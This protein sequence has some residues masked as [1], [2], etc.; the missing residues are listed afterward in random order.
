MDTSSSSDSH[1]SFLKRLL[2]L[3]GLFRAPDSAEDI[4]QEIQEILEEGEEQ[5]LISKDEGRLITSILEFKDTLAHE[6]MTPRSDMVCAAAS[7]DVSEIISLIVDK[8]YT[9]IPIYAD[10]P[11]NIVG[12]LH[13]KDLL[14]YCLKTDNLP[15]ASELVKP[16]FFVMETRKI[17]DLLKDF[18]NQ[19]IHMG[20][21]TDEFGSVRGLVTLEDVVEEIVG[22][23]RDEYDKTE[24]KWKV[25]H[26]DTVLVD[27]RVDIEEVEEFFGVEM[28][29]GPYESVGGLIIYQLDRVPETGSTLLI[30]SLVFEVVSASKRKINTVKVQKKP[31]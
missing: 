29:E 17:V 23:I 11:D 19:K 5:G 10:S 31:V 3:I 24:R 22:E 1:E 15:S 7:A 8:G 12:I 28:P 6:I 26:P 16:P 14:P 4:E 13:A 9:R 30:N 2:N 27:A 20:I 21:V 18:Q 25:V